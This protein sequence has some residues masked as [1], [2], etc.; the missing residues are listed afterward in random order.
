LAPKALKERL[1]RGSSAMGELKQV[2]L[3]GFGGQGVVL[4]GTILGYAAIKDGKWVAG[5]S[6]Y[7]A[8]ARGGSARSDVVVSDGL[9][10][11]P[12]VIE[13]DILVAMAQTAYIRYMEELSQG[14]WVIYDDELVSPQSIADAVQIGV[15]ATASAI[16]ELKQQQS[17]NIVILGALAAIT[18]IASKRALRAAIEENISERFRELNLKALELGYKLGGRS[19]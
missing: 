3:S 16:K 8:Q 5:S 1:S 13:A 19:A 15:P 14:A 9:I 6:S 17:A 2:R 18:G 10:I 7:G 11:F 12:H 4:A